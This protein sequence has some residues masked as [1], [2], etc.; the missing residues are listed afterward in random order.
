[1]GEPVEVAVEG[2]ERRLEEPAQRQALGVVDR[3]EQH[4]RR[5]AQHDKQRSHAGA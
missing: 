4:A 1:M 3:R 5:L 2:R